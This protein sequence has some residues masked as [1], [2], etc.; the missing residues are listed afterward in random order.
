MFDLIEHICTLTHLCHQCPPP[1]PRVKAA[2]PGGADADLSVGLHHHAVTVSLTS[3]SSSFGPAAPWTFVETTPQLGSRGCLIPFKFLYSSL[4]SSG[5]SLHL[6]WQN[7]PFLLHKFTHLSHK[8]AQNPSTRT[9]LPEWPV[10]SVLWGGGWLGR[11]CPCPS[12]LLREMA[13]APA[14]MLQALQEAQW[15][16]RVWRLF[17]GEA[18]GHRQNKPQRKPWSE[19]IHAPQCSLQHRLQ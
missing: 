15:G 11:T 2:L 16:D 5:L 12:V 19:R 13:W 10:I 3:W 14:L 9:A 8:C 7:W 18:Q 1:H 17:R 4:P 6:R